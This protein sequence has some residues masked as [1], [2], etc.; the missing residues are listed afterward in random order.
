MP[1]TTSKMRTIL[2]GKGL[3]LPDLVSELANH[4]AAVFAEA[5][6][7]PATARR[8]HCYGT[9]QVSELACAARVEMTIGTVSEPGDVPECPL[10]DGI[11]AFLKQER[12]DPEQ[13]EFP[14]PTSQLVDV[15]LHAV[16]DEHQGIDPAGLCLL[17]GVA[18]YPG[19]LGLACRTDYACHAPQQ[20]A[21]TGLP[22]TRLELAKTSVEAK[23]D[24]QTSQGGGFLEHLS[25]ELAGLIPGRFTTG[26]RVHGKDEPS[27]G[28]PRL[29]HGRSGD[30]AQEGIDLTG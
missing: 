27:A 7:R 28:P 6:Q 10:G 17:H 18:Q 2:A 8:I 16:A 22:G 21:R 12:G 13:A 11:V 3:T 20:F 1:A 9:Q 23:L 4:G 29:D 30:L 26:S 15:L 5:L 25:L 24:V 19:D 14:R